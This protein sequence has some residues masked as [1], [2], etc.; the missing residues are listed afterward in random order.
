MTNVLVSHSKPTWL[1]KS[2]KTHF[3]V[4]HESAFSLSCHWH[5]PLI[6][7][8]Y[9]MVIQGVKAWWKSPFT[10]PPYPTRLPFLTAVGW[11][12]FCSRVLLHGNTKKIKTPHLLICPSLVVHFSLAQAVSF[13]PCRL[14]RKC[15]WL[16]LVMP[17]IKLTNSYCAVR[18]LWLL[19]YLYSNI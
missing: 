16:Y 19:L 8:C 2:R 9:N 15:T 3:I 11:T 5:E 12:L 6:F 4:K 13:L 14:N 18:K 10:P 7:M 17:D 1:D